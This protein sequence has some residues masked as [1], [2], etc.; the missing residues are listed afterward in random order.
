MGRLVLD[1]VSDLPPARLVGRGP[2]LHVFVGNL[3]Y[4]LSIDDIGQTS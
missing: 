2:D 1:D 3:W 4:R